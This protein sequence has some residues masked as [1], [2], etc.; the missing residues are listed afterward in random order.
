[1]LAIAYSCIAPLV[2]GFAAAGVAL[3]YFAYRYNLLFTLQP[4]LDTRGLAYI[5]ALQHLLT[6]LYI[7]ELALIG[8]F[9][10]R[11][12][13]GPVVIVSVLLVGTIAF[14]TL[15]NKYLAPLEHFIPTEIA[16]SAA[17]QISSESTPLLRAEEGDEESQAAE[18]HIQRLAQRAHA[19]EP[20]TRHVIK[21]VAKFFEPNVFASYEA[22]RRWL[23]EGCDYHNGT[24][25]AVPYDEDDVP[26]YTEDQ[27]RKAYLNPVLTSP[28]P[29]VWLARD[30]F[31]VSA[32][33]VAEIEACGLKASDRG[34]WL[35]EKGK[36][37]WNKDDFSEVPIWKEKVVY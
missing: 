25:A 7:G 32:V 20:V 33:E 4:K 5:L 19:P 2:L 29:P 3:Y 11:K 27:L 14:N 16:S 12:A 36:L 35:D 37:R 22:M 8:F 17:S 9:G 10:L 1:M 30:G 28:T 13:T 31:S 18:S 24:A 15:M 21:P 26:R 23:R 6:G 34:A